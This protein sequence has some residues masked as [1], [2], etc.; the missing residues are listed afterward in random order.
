MLAFLVSIALL[1][2]KLYALFAWRGFFNRKKATRAI[3]S[4]RTPPLSHNVIAA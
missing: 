2:F 1:C 3:P 4:D